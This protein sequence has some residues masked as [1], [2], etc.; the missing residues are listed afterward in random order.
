M[1]ESRLMWGFTLLHLQ[2]RA[3]R[4]SAGIHHDSILASREQARTVYR[5][6]Q[7]PA[8]HGEWAVYR[9]IVGSSIDVVTK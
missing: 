5:T 4:G 7:L 8:A 6:G 9:V 3:H 2:F 1:A